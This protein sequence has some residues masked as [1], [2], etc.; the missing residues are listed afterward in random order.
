[1]ETTYWHSAVADRGGRATLISTDIWK[2][3]ELAYHL[4]CANAAELSS[5]LKILILLPMSPEED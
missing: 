2:Y 5:L 3:L 1:M 4:Y